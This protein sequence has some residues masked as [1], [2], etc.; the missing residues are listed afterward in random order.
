M[1]S[2]GTGVGYVVAKVITKKQ[3]DTKVEFRMA[4]MT[5]CIYK[6]INI[7]LQGLDQHVVTMRAISDPYY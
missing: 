1:G 4:L 6:L 7:P 2:G 5:T 3:D